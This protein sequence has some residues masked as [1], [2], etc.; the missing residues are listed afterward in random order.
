MKKAMLTPKEKVILGNYI[1][2]HCKI[3]ENGE[4]AQWDEESGGSDQTVV[5]KLKPLIPR[6]NYHHISNMRQAFD[7]RLEP[8]RIA[9]IPPHK[10]HEMTELDKLRDK[11]EALTAHAKEQDVRLKEYYTRL[12]E[13]EVQ[14][15]DYE[16]RLSAMEDKYTNPKATAPMYISRG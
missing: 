12:N 4:Y 10:R 13:H 16:K 6:I 8:Q 14:L 3:P 11:L 2:A 7:L 9:W 5:E 1:V 15:N